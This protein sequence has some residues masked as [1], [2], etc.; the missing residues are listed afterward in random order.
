MTRTHKR[1][2]GR[3]CAHRAGVESSHK[4]T[5]STGPNSRNTT[6]TQTHKRLPECKHSPRHCVQRQ[7]PFFIYV[8]PFVL[9]IISS[10]II[11]LCSVRFVVGLCSFALALKHGRATLQEGRVRGVPA[12]VKPYGCDRVGGSGP[13]RSPN[14]T[15]DK[16]GRGCVA[17][18][19]KVLHTGLPPLTGKPVLGS[20]LCISVQQTGTNRIDGGA[21]T[22]TEGV[23]HSAQTR[24]VLPPPPSDLPEKWCA[25][26]EERVPHAASA[27]HRPVPRV[28][29]VPLP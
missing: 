17:L 7:P 2:P 28:R 16:A 9:V 3:T 1:L 15:V 13:L 14:G 23:C 10:G 6:V 24:V 4:V 12:S 29:Q 11:S 21:G 25:R 5:V 26:P 20:A 8:S 18:R 19:G 22:H 27:D